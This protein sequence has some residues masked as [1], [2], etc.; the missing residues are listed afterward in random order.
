MT[1][2][3]V[4]YKGI[5]LVF[6]SE[7]S[8]YLVGYR[9]GNL[10]KKEIGEF[11]NDIVEYGIKK[12]KIKLFVIWSLNIFFLVSKI[13]FE[14][15]F[16]KDNIDEMRGIADGSKQPYKWIFLSNTIYDLGTY[17]SKIFPIQ[18]CSSFVF[19]SRKNIYFG[20]VTDTTKYLA[21]IFTKY[22]V[23]IVYNYTNI[24]KRYITLTLPMALIGDYVLFDNLTTIGVNGGGLSYAKYFFGKAPYI[25]YVKQLARECGDTKSVLNYLKK[26]RSFKPLLFMIS[27]PKIEDNYSVERT[28]GIGIFPLEKYL[29]NTNHL[30]D[31]NNVDKFYIKNYMK[32]ENYQKSKKKYQTIEDNIRG[33]N[34]YMDAIDIL[35]QHSKNFESY[36]GSISNAATTQGL[37][38]DFEKGNMYIP[39]GKRV[40]VT[41]FGK[42]KKFNIHKIFEMI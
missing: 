18:L 27:G 21:N 4:V 8:P 9:Q 28:G 25:A 7:N 20:K 42:W 34:N 13:L 37:V 16:S 40:P 36:K 15:S 23:V 1:G 10:L 17:F 26:R 38:I 24:G 41:F 2:K 30:N 11:I 19:R 32:D 33:A 6:I 35:K 22:N 29:I 12:L 39:K 3:K 31:K 14:K 5:K